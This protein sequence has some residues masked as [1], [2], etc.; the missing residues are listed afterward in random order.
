LEELVDVGEFSSVVDV[1]D[2]GGVGI[3]KAGWGNGWG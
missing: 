1:G 3:H 2:D